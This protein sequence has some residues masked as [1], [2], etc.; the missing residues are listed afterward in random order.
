MGDI[1]LKLFDDDGATLLDSSETTNDVEYVDYITNRSGYLHVEVFP[2]LYG[3]N[4][5]WLKIVKVNTLCEIDMYEPNDA[6]ESAA[7]ISE[8]EFEQLTIC[9]DEDWYTVE[10]NQGEEIHVEISFSSIEGDLDLE[11][12][13]EDVNEPVAESKTRNDVESVTYSGED[14]GLYYIRVF[15]YYEDT[16]NAYDLS[17]SIL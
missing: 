9:G 13:F 16:L 11:L 15:P 5:Y 2:Y 6:R 7:G 1:D 3:N 17:I 4:L 12:Y 8:G 10:L 14:W